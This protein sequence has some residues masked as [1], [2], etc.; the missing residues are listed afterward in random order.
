MTK[1][2]SSPQYAG[3]GVMPEI[4]PVSAETAL[5]VAVLESPAT[6]GSGPFPPSPSALR[7]ITHPA[8]EGGG[9]PSATLLGEPDLAQFDLQSGPGG[10]FDPDE[11]LQLESRGLTSQTPGR[12]GTPKTRVD[13]A[14]FWAAQT[15]FKNSIAA[16]LREAGRQ[17][18]A[19]ALEFCHSEYTFAVCDGC[20]RVTKFPNRCDRHYCPECQPRLA[21]ERRESVEW[22]TKEI[23]QPKHVVLTLHNVPDLVRGHITEAKDFLSALR[24]QVFCSKVTYHWQ[25]NEPMPLDVPPEERR[26]TTERIKTFRQQTR[27][28]HTV[29]CTPWIGGFYGM[30]ITNEGNGFHI[31]F[32]LLVDA[33]S[34]GPVQLSQAWKAATKGAGYI[35]CVKD[36]RGSSY[37]QELT[38]YTVK[39]SQLAEW[40][41]AHIVQFIEALDGVRTFGVFGSLYGKRSEFAAWLEELRGH[42][43]TCPCG[44]CDAHYY[45][46]AEFLLLDLRPT[47]PTKPKPPVLV[48]HPE[49]TLDDPRWYGPR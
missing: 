13:Q 11:P 43:P 42:K 38:K 8:D 12:P 15:T 20:N 7:Q 18:L 22:W 14:E 17:D 37:L 24:R 4:Q 46:E 26:Y 16:K 33:R 6:T 5:P 3:A 36:A 31:H 28:H 25:S 21:A 47:I 39:G 34:I 49:F 41:P 27:T 10:R 40:K 30:E 45:S 29:I 23:S 44:C 35:V 32:H 19:Q 1:G 9:I 2:R 48:S